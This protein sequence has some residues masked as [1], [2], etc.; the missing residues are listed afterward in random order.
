MN[1]YSQW[2]GPL[3][4]LTGIVALVVSVMAYR[5][6]SAM[7]TLDLRLELHRA[8]DNLDILTSGIEDFFEHVRQSHERVLAATD[9][10][11]SGQWTLFEENF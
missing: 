9:G 8:S 11:R 4:A 3:G 6:V 1:D 7:K 2:T 10:A 5:R